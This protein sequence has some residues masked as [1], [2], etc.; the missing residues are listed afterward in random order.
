VTAAGRS[1]NGKAYFAYFR[2]FRARL[3]G[4]AIAGLLQS[5]LYAPLALL[6]RNVFDVIL[7][8]LPATGAGPLWKACAEILGLQLASFALAYAI[9]LAAERISEEVLARMRTQGI[10]RLYDLPRSFHT[11]MDAEALH[12]ALVYETNWIEKMNTALTASLMPGLMSCAV[13]MAILFRIEPRFAAALGIALPV[14]FALNRLTSREVWFRQEGLRNA[15]EEFSRG[16]RFAIGA[17]DLTRSH[18]CEP[19]EI[20]RQGKRVER[21]K[22]LSIDLGKLTAGLQLGQAALLISFTLMALVAG[23]YAVAQGALTRGGIMAFYAAAALFAAQARIV[24]DTI[25]DFRMGMR[26]FRVFLGVLDNAEREPYAGGTLAMD[27]WLG[28]DAGNLSFSYGGRPILAGAS[29]S[30]QPGEHIVMLGANGSGKSSL[31]HLIA[32]YYRP[33]AGTIATGGSGYDGLDMRSLRARL[34]IV[35]QNPLLF[36]GTIRENVV[37]GSE[38]VSDE[39]FEEA[40]REAGALD[41]VARQAQ[42]AE[43]QIGDNGVRLSGGERQRLAIARALLRRPDLLILDEPTNHLDQDGIEELMK[44]LK[45]LPFRPAVLLISHER[46]VVEYA[47]RAWRLRDGKLEEAPR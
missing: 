19:W 41:V 34:A 32:G 38:N 26:A 7:P 15:F 9:R 35:P 12:M 39:A 6:L 10:A 46:R 3:A 5:A 27:R 43:T 8:A 16:V 42:G 24:V 1:G 23:G 2:P 25:P 31:I 47:D 14:L 13:L 40:L 18:A 28:L 30:I 4:V 45:R 33:S 17:I 37:Y 20:D 44:S 29:L 21:L 22:T 36:T 11:A